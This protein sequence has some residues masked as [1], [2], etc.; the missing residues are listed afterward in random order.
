[1]RYFIDSNNTLHAYTEEQVAQGYGQEMIEWEEPI[2]NG[3]VLPQHKNIDKI[4]CKPDGSFYTKYNPDGTPDIEA[5]KQAKRKE[6]AQAR[7]EAETGGLPL[8]NGY[9]VKTDRES[10]AMLMAAALSAKEDPNYIVNW[11][12][13]NGWM[14]IDAETI[15]KVAQAVREHVEMCF[16]KERLLHEQID[17]CETIEE[18][19]AIEW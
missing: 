1:M 10:Q 17:K 12:C 19:E 6:I 5:E 3:K 13:A 18:V 2:F 15:L 11:K 8:P 4:V 16:D 7:Y 9:I 14:Q